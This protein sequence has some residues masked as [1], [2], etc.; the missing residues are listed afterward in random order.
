M[1]VFLGNRK[2]G[3][4]TGH[5]EDFRETAVAAHVGA[6][7]AVISRAVSQNSSPRAV[8]E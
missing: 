8:A 1:D 7:D 4:A 5:G 3:S 2:T 6:D